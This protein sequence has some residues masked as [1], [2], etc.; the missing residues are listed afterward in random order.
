MASLSQE[1]E[2]PDPLFDQLN[3]EFHFMID[4]CASESNH[5]LPNYYTKQQNCFTKDWTQTSWIN[6]EFVRVKKFVQKAFEDSMK[7]GS[8]IVMIIMVKS[9]TNWW[10][11]YVMKAKE[12]RF[13][14]QKVQF[15]DTKQGLRFPCAIVI[16]APHEGE[17]K[18]SVLEQNTTQGFGSSGSK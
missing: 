3:N 12:V 11:D 2:T 7:F 15:K 4:I 17:T 16:F 6:P 14:N 1:Y 8:T 10:R 13:I 9:N 5:K 18:F